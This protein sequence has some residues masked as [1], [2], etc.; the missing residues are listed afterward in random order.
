MALLEV[1]QNQVTIQGSKAKP[2][3]K[4]KVKPNKSKPK[5]RPHTSRRGHMAIALGTLDLDT[6]EIAIKS[7]NFA[8]Y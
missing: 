7:W 5:A 2:K 8:F 1:I 3:A 6:E 4:V